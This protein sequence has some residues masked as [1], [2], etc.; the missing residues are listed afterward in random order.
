MEENKKTTIQEVKEEVVNQEVELEK[1]VEEISNVKQTF[2]ESKIAEI[3]AEEKN[4]ILFEKDIDTPV[5]R[6]VV[7]KL[8][9]S[10]EGI[11]GVF[12]GSEEDGYNYIIGSKTIDCR[13]IAT[14]LREELNAR[15]GGKAPMI[16]GSVVAAEAN[17]RK[18][19]EE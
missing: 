11:C 13:N 7:N 15:G 2:M 10:H 14:K 8:V 4:V 3:S 18:I 12:V 1:T 9:E 17:I 16:Q 19:L 6:N 5:M